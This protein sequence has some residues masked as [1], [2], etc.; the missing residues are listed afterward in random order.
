[1]NPMEDK[2][3]PRFRFRQA[4][5]RVCAVSVLT[6][7]EAVPERCFRP[8]TGQHSNRAIRFAATHPPSLQRRA[9]MKPLPS[10]LVLLA[11]SLPLRPDESEEKAVRAVE[12]AFGKITRDDKLPG[13]PVVEIDLSRSGVADGGLVEMA[14]FKGL[15]VL[16]LY[17][18]KVSDVGFKALGD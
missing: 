5:G 1:S 10:A 18:S 8:R 14:A 15:R 13:K 4:G 17:D 9:P 7:R 3:R 12:K 6:V 2:A 16:S 11:V